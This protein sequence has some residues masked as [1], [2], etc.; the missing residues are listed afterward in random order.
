MFVNFA[1]VSS[2]V[3]FNAALR[4]EI[5]V[6][7]CGKDGEAHFAPPLGVLDTVLGRATL[8]PTWK[9]VT[10]TARAKVEVQ[11]MMINLKKKG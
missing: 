7:R 4:K 11:C 8:V 10:A 5:S 9:A 2:G 3:Y 6:W 1:C